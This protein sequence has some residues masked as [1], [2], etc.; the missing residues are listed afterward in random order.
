MAWRGIWRIALVAASL[1]EARSVMVEGPSGLFA[2]APGSVRPVWE[3]SLRCLPRPGGAHATLFS[4]TEPESL[5][6]PGRSHA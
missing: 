3:P 1:A 2:I 4:A 5:R 6:G